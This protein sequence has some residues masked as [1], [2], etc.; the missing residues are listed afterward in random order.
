MRFLVP[1][2]PEPAAAGRR[3]LAVEVAMAG[4]VSVLL[5]VMGRAAAPLAAAAA[6]PLAAAG[7]GWWWRRR[8]Q[9]GRRRRWRW[10]GW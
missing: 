5:A 7:I 9:R 10:Q 6:V 4:K 8:R 2:W 3:V 1:T